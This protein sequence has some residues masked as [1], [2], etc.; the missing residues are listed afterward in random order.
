MVRLYVEMR[1]RIKPA[2]EAE[3]KAGDYS[4]EVLAK[5][6]EELAAC[7]QEV[8]KLHSGDTENRRLWEMFM[9]W[10]M[11]AIEP[12]YRRLDVKFDHSLGESFY[13]PML[14]D[15]V[16]GL[17]Y[18][19]IARETKGAIGI[20][21]S[22][23]E[24]EPPALIR[25]SS[26]AYG[27]MTTDLATV[28]YRAKEWQPAEVLYVVG[29]PQALHFKQLFAIAERWGYG[30]TAYHHIGFGSVLTRKEDGTVEML[31]TRKGGA[32][33]LGDLL[34]RSEQE[35]ARRYEEQCRERRE[36]GY[37]VPALSVEE[38]HE[39]HEV[40]GLGAVK[41]ADLS[42]S[43]ESDYVF[44]WDKML[45]T[46]GNTATYMQ[47]AYARVRSIFREGD[48][49]AERFREQPPPVYLQMPEERTLALRLLQ[50]PEALLSAAA[51]YRPNLITN[52]L[53]D[54]AKAYSGF[55]DKCDVLKAETPQLRQGRLLLCDLT[56]R[57]IQ[58]GLDLLGIR[59]VERM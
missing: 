46:V 50:F 18:K 11:G 38:L 39:L 36:R 56:A 58:K 43:R 49:V 13:N 54:L 59:T 17:L 53:F 2:E 26:G 21:L 28:Q 33:E 42:Q 12:I 47:Y 16:V 57:T 8:V 10:C 40:I 4:A 30:N 29:S 23:K 35:A 45:A 34:D 15:L 9:P 3:D 1:K 25:Y 31:G 5:S 48:E 22:D 44:D 37:A 27:Y 14:A 52:Y 7:R 51:D 6:R 20:F 55:Y 41:Y 32:A 24:G 19:G